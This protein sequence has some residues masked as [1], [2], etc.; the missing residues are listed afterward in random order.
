[1][2][3][4]RNISRSLTSPDAS[5][6]TKLGT[7]SGEIKRSPSTARHH[8]RSADR[9]G[10]SMPS[11]GSDDILIYTHGLLKFRI[12]RKVATISKY[13]ESL[14]TNSGTDTIN[15]DTVQFDF[16][17]N[18]DV[19][20]ALF[21]YFNIHAPYFETETTTGHTMHTQPLGADTRL[22]LAVMIPTAPLVSSDLSLCYTKYSAATGQKVVNI[23][24]QF[25]EEFTRA[26]LR[27]SVEANGNGGKEAHTN[28]Y[29]ELFQLAVAAEHFKMDSLCHLIAAQIATIILKVSMSDGVHLRECTIETAIREAFD[30]TFSFADQPRGPVGKQNKEGK[31]VKYINW[32]NWWLT[33]HEHAGS[34]DMKKRCK[35]WLAL[36]GLAAQLRPLVLSYALRGSKTTRDLYSELKLITGWHGCC[37][38]RSCEGEYFRSIE[39]SD[40][41]QGQKER[42]LDG[43]DIED[44]E[45]TEDPY[46]T[47]GS[48]VEVLDVAAGFRHM[49]LLQPNGSVRT[50]RCP[51]PGPIEA[52]LVDVTRVCVTMN[53]C[54][55]LTRQGSVYCWTTDGNLVIRVLS[56]VKSIHVTDHVL[57]AHLQNGTL[58]A[59]NTEP[60]TRRNS[61]ATE[62]VRQVDNFVGV[63]VVCT[64]P[65]GVAILTTSSR[66]YAWGC[67]WDQAHTGQGT[68]ISRFS[69]VLDDVASLH[70]D[71]KSFTA[72]F[73]TTKPDLTWRDP[74]A[75]DDE[76]D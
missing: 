69:G 67:L 56:E 47:R 43:E 73:N 39:D 76:S 6:D 62:L 16:L 4:N 23:D 21:G 48:P 54:C 22:D 74:I 34:S 32:R 3:R 11:S 10:G 18:R 49:A 35:K 25:I 38:R 65:T 41:R 46:A 75:S 26:G 31:Y 42:C 24:V 13:L 17:E 64:V 29:H 60:S 30:S 61:V 20:N 15:I 51:P 53:A 70:G 36:F 33:H 1:M 19:C 27:R 12:R 28:P 8:R 7:V 59:R 45:D 40:Y 52:Q 71:G 14:M 57:I 68:H 63:R 72:R 58:V 44:L 5:M 50:W 55:A 37:I 2:S 66:L 9:E